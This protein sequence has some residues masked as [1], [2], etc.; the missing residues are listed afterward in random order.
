MRWIRPIGF[1]V[2]LVLGSIGFD[3]FV[4][5]YDTGQWSSSASLLVAGS[6]LVLAIA[7]VLVSSHNHHR[8]HGKLFWIAL[9]TL[10]IV[11]C[12]GI[13]SGGFLGALAAVLMYLPMGLPFGLVIGLIGSWLLNNRDRT[14][15]AAQS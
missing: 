13:G 7:L 3:L 8:G 10:V 9:S 14:G 15:E 4:N 2:L 11:L 12:F 6:A 1:V 5:W